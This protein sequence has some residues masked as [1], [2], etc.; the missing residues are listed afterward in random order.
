MNARPKRA[1]LAGAAIVPVLV[2]LVAVGWNRH[3][4]P[5]PHDEPIQ[6]VVPVP[7]ALPSSENFGD[8]AA[9][10]LFVAGRRPM[11]SRNPAG[12]AAAQP[13]S[14]VL[15]AVI[16]APETRS[17]LLRPQN[18][19]VVSVTE[20]QALEG[21]TVAEIAADH[22]LLRAGGTEYRLTFPKPAAAPARRPGQ[23]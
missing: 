23:H 1:A 21:W 14:T 12:P 10:S 13:P 15:L 6:T 11:P 5:P 2:L 20:G 19:K 22:V 4:L 3:A 18:R 7:R 8:I 16:L 17:A 9:R